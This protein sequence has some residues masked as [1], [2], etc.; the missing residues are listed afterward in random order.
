VRG[1]VATP[2]LPDRTVTKRNTYS[3]DPEFLPVTE[4][5]ELLR[6]TPTAFAWLGIAKNT[7]VRKTIV[8][9]LRDSLFNLS[10]IFADNSG[11]DASA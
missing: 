11:E 1:E 8:M 9:N 4:K 6:T 10:P 2:G 3:S 5:M 7:R